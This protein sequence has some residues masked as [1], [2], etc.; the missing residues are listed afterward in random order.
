MAIPS[1]FTVT[2]IEL[3][4]R[5]KQNPRDRPIVRNSRNAYDLFLMSWN[6]NR[7]NLV[8]DFKILLQDRRCACLGIA[9]IASGS[10]NECLVD[11]KIVFGI[12]L[13]AKASALTLAHNHPSGC[14]QPSQPDM[15][16]TR[17]FKMAGEFLNIRVNDHLIITP[18][19]YYSFADKGMMP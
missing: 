15:T 10:I 4:Y 14:V 12:A 18:R 3:V 8:E 5:N 6:M 7:I 17:Q 13:K 19:D 9:P 1:L 2:E 16:L 11:P